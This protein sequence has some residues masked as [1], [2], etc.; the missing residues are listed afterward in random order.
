MSKRL[1]PIE[2][3]HR[4]LD[5]L[6]SSERDRWDSGLTNDYLEIEQIVDDLKTCYEDNHRL[7]EDNYQLRKYNERLELEIK[8]LK[9]DK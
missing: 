7:H 6:V 3:V 1:L 2:R 8:R 4:V 9:E 5:K